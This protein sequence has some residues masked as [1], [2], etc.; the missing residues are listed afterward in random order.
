MVVIEDTQELP[1]T[2][3]LQHGF[4]IQ[5]LIVKPPVSK[6][7]FELDADDA[8]KTALRLGESVL[9]VGEVRGR[10][11]R[12]LFEAM[13]VGAA[14]S[15]VLGTIHSGSAEDVFDRIVNDLNVPRTSFK[16]VDLIITL[17]QLSEKEYG[18]KKRIIVEITEI[19][20]DWD[21]KPEFRKI[22]YFDFHAKK[23]RFNDLRKSLFLRKIL[24]MNSMNFSDFKKS[25]AIRKKMKCINLD[26]S[27]AIANNEKIRQAIKNKLR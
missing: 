14:G 20:K 2:E 22:A 1:C 27:G 5:R 3:L 4:N 19:L 18:A 17:G 21:T 7:E 26:F 12:T 10:E 9:V 11:A 23:L 6:N 25:I 24:K 16:A 13:R 15:C 8:L